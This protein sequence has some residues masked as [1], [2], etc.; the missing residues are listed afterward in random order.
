MSIN[1]C[2]IVLSEGRKFCERDG[3][4]TFAA[5]SSYQLLHWIKAIVMF[6]ILAKKNDF[7]NRNSQS[8]I[9][10]VYLHI[11]SAEASQ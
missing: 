11:D 8:H 3:K 10:C 5:N 2:M 9:H 1:L 7:H 4:T 6:V